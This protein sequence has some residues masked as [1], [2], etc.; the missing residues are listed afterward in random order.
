MKALIGLVLIFV[1]AGCDPKCEKDNQGR[2][3]VPNEY[4]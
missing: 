1:L 3:T 4:E 2:D